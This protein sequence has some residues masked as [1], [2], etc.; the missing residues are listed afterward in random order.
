MR[1]IFGRVR[2]GDLVRMERALHGFAIYALGTGPTF[3]S[4]QYDHGPNWPVPELFA[5][6]I[7]LERADLMIGPVERRPHLGMYLV[8]I[9]SGYGYHVRFV[10]GD[11]PHQVHAEMW[12]A[13]DWAYH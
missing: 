3:G 4:L 10:A 6:S 5:A 1:G 12:P 11:D 2:D 13:L 8:G 9:V 7:A